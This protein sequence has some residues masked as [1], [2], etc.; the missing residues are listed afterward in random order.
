MIEQF[1]ALLFLARDMAH[2]AHLTTESYA[3]HMALGEFYAALPELA[4]SLAETWQGLNDRLGDIPLLENKAGTD[5]VKALQAQRVWIER[6]R[7]ELGNS[8]TIQNIVDEI[9]Q[10]YGQTLYKLRFLG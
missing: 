1:V 4:D 6:N 2:R 3:K 5:I 7:K 9:V 10:Q 8:T